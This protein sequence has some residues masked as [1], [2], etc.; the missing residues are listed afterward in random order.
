MTERIDRPTSEDLIF[1][2]DSW[3]KSY[4]TS[5]M[6]TICTPI[7]LRNQGKMSAEYARGQQMLIEALLLRGST[8]VYKDGDFIIGWACAEPPHILHY[9]YVKYNF[10]NGGVSRKL[11]SHFDL[12]PRV[13]ISHLSRDMDFKR[14]PK[15]FKFTPY[16]A[17]GLNVW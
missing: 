12:A 3:L 11:I 9:V 6:A 2:K 5:V 13:L 17:M 15:R 14:L 8:F 10:R 16:A 7:T 1:I 4:R